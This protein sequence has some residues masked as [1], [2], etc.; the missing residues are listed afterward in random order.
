MSVMQMKASGMIIHRRNESQSG[1]AES[2]RSVPLLI[3]PMK[4]YM[5]AIIITVLIST[6]SRVYIL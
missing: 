5:P 2:A 3:A 1:R 6:G 4:K